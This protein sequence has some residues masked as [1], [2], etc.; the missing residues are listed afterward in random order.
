MQ[1][2]E[3]KVV[4]APDRGVKE[5]GARTAPERFAAAL[6][7]RIN[8]MAREGWEFVRSETLP[9]E[10]RTGLTGR[11]TVYHAV[12]VFRRPLAAAPA[13]AAPPAA[14]RSWFPRLGPAFGSRT[15]AEA[16][17]L[18]PA[19]APEPHPGPEAPPPAPSPAPDAAPPGA[20]LRLR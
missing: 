20:R 2:F 18:G 13:E 7:Q 6:G 5:R 19:T 14:Q 10:E 4:P 11:T 8:A 16:P 12:L 15:E 1:S 9:S 3:Y 17:P